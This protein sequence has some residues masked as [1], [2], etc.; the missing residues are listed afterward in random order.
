MKFERRLSFPN[1]LCDNEY[2]PIL[3]SYFQSLIFTLERI[4]VLYT[5]NM[6][7]NRYS[8]RYHKL[9]HNFRYRA[10]DLI[11]IAINAVYLFVLFF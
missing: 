8:I 3:S 7:S 10:I 9:L 2:R 4:N 1:Q 6:C 11:S 5:I